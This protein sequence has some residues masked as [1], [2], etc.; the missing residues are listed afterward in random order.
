MYTR[1]NLY[2]LTKFIKLLAYTGQP[3]EAAL[4]AV[5]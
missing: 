2:A 1:S 4:Y 5:T 3:D